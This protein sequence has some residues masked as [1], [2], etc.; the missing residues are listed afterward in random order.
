MTCGLEAPSMDLLLIAQSARMLAQSA[1]LAGFGVYAIDCF[2]DDDLCH[3]SE[4]SIAV[5]NFDEASLFTAIG[6]IAPSSGEFA[7]VYG[8][9]IDTR[10]ALLEKLA[11]NYKVLGNLP[12]T[13]N[14]INN[15][16]NFSHLLDYLGVPYPETCFST[17]NPSAGWLSKPI[18][19]EG[20]KSISFYANRQ[21]PSANVYYQR[22]MQ[23]EAH[24]LLFLAN[25][26][27]IRSIGFNTQW[28]SQHDLAQPFLF[29]GAVNRTN[30]SARQR[31]S[32]ESYATKLTAAVGLV[33]LNSLDF[34][35][36]NGRCW[37]LE[38]NARPSASMALY[39]EDFAEGLLAL[40][41]ASCLGELPPPG[42]HAGPVRALSIVYN[43]NT[44]TIPFDF[45]WP[46]GYADIPR[47][48][49]RIESGQPLCSILVQG[50]DRQAVETLVKLQEQKILS[51]L[52]RNQEDQY[53]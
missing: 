17:P 24:S 38:I 48:G 2:G 10:P 39:D 11:R 47:G 4:A 25:G 37:V 8:S 14:Q 33:G 6:A 12:P 49:T 32:I 20:G 44:M 50:N 35:A 5:D 53:D 30:L 19:R 23:G 29:G 46:E 7:L 28:T 15:P 1:A 51:G 16:L 42:H 36:E 45:G 3:L 13:L 41:I 31:K 52:Q 40:H 18:G 27:G 43:P 34:I 26:K 21:L 22:F 9:G